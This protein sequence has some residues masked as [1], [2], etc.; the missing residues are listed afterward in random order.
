MQT[1]DPIA[2]YLT[3]VRNSIAARHKRVDIP[4]SNL[5]REITK[6]LVEKKYIAGYSEIKDNRQGVLRLALKY[7][8]GVNAITG[9]RR[10]SRPGLRVYKPADDLPRVLNGLGIAVISTSRGILT[11]R[12]AAAKKIGGEVLCHIW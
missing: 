10:I 6:I 11:D 4:A 7:T 3:R 9:L 2:D 12:D 1:T 8:D 5:K